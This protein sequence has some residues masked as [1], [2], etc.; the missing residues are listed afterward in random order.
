MEAIFS[1]KYVGNTPD[2]LQSQMPS[3]ESNFKA[4]FT[5][6]NVWNK[7]SPMVSKSLLSC[8]SISKNQAEA[9]QIGLIL[10]DINCSKQQQKSH[11]PEGVAISRLMCS[12]MGLD[13]QVSR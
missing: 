2:G 9:F 5:V 1:L 13:V 10:G 7:F 12:I 8:I 6:R 4:V 11:F 3:W